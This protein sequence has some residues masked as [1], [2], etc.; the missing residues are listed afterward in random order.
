M[1]QNKIFYTQSAWHYWVQAASHEYQ[2]AHAAARQQERVQY[3]EIQKI[4][5]KPVY[6]RDCFDDDGVR[7]LN[8][9]IGSR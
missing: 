8:R 4:V 3:V 5:E 1:Q 9:A 7:E 2:A 6:M